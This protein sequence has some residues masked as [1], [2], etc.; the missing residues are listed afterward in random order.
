MAVNQSDRSV[1]SLGHFN[2]N[3]KQT[4]VLLLLKYK[5]ISLNVRTKRNQYMMC[6][7]KPQQKNCV[8][9]PV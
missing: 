5:S 6:G 9:S 7:Y 4:K 1:F 8:I 2:S 3:K